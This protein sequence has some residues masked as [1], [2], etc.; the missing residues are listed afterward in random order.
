[1]T[2]KQLKRM[3]KEL[4]ELEKQ[5][6]ITDDPDFRLKVEKK[7]MQ[8]NDAADLTVDEMIELDSMIQDLLTE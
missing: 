8:I 6:K 4:A 7:I 1:M 3:A 2:R 5:L